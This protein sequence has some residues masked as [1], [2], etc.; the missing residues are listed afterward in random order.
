MVQVAGDESVTTD[1]RAA[2]GIT[3]TPAAT[4][5]IPAATASRQINRC[6]GIAANLHSRPPARHRVFYR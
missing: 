2:P 5:A 4:T 1:V 3:K 6:S